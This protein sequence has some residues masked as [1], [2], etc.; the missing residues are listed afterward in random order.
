M[1]NHSWNFRVKYYKNF[2]GEVCNNFKER[3]EK[4]SGYGNII[5]NLRKFKTF[6]KTFKKICCEYRIN[7]GTICKICN[8]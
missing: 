4:I 3:V 2:G 1:Y 5:K 7:F 8:N 6:W